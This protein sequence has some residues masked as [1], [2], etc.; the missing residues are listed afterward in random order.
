MSNSKKKKIK[1]Y[2]NRSPYPWQQEVH[3]YISDYRKLPE[4]SGKTIVIKAARQVYGK[5][6]F[7]KAELI[8]F[9]L[10]VAGSENAYVSP[11]LNLARKM[12]KGV[13]RSTRA[14]IKSSNS[15]D[16]EIEFRNGSTIRFHSE[17]QGEALRGF[18]VTGLL[19]IDEA[20]SFKDTSFYELIAPWT[21]VHKALV[22]IIS[23]PKYKMGF[24]YENYLDG[25]DDD[26]LYY[27][28]FDWV[29]RYNV[30]ISPEDLA[31]K[32]K[33]PVLKWRS[34][35]EGMFLDAEGAVFGDFSKC[36]IDY[37]KQ[38]I[39]EIYLGLD[40]GTGTGKDFTVL[41]GF[42][43][44]GRQRFIWA[45]NDMPPMQQV[46]KIA[47][48]VNKFKKQVEQKNHYTGAIDITIENKV[49]SFYAEQNSIGKVYIDAL[50]EEGVE[51]T[52]FNTDNTSKRKLVE[53]FQIGL[54]NI[55]IGLLKDQEQAMQL[56]FYESTVDSKTNKVSYNAPKGFHDDYV[57][58][59][60][61][62]YKAYKTKGR[63]LYNV[64]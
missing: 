9:A 41:T 4:K 56:S 25:L 42:D 60:M 15:I 46:R 34:E 50:K 13:K 7:S 39:D 64:M 47:E 17:Q 51:V 5:T 2:G 26:N 28:T 16:M 12:F 63:K 40:F 32:N 22:V 61:L 49:K 62:A 21:T 1:I 55:E 57:I 14:F 11:K 31:K 38:D 24:F 29:Y 59:V 23:T 36:L 44:R 43:E 35:Y 52:K 48:I 45:V 8:R 58:A 54:Q 3:D 30:P 10:G 27:K 20:S 37:L 53:D 18:T 19:V 33:M 6:S